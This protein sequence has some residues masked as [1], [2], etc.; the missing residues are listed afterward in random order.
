MYRNL[1]QRRGHWVEVCV[2][3]VEGAITAQDGGA[4]R[5]E[6]CDNLF[7]G[8]TTPSAGTIA[9]TRHHL[10]IDL[11]V[12][13]RPRGGDFCYSE[14]EFEVMRR[15]IEEARRLGANGVVI[16][17]LTPDGSIDIDRTRVLIDLA[18][19]LSVTFHRAFDVCRDPIAALETLIDLGVDRL[20]TSGQEA[21]VLEGLDLISELVRRAG[22]R[23]IIMPGGGIREHHLPKILAVGVKEIHV[24]ARSPVSS[25]MIHRNGRVSMGGELRLPEYERKTTDA[26]RVRA[27]VE[28]RD[29]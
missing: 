11:N 26:A 6:L 25:P 18:R 3:S 16:G 10:Q 9:L 5:V 19:P 2:D 29:R 17:L 14:I 15:D 8:G 20:L 7:E 23:I 27:F 12:I 28:N 1:E 22:D 24:S 4:A 13:I 21:S